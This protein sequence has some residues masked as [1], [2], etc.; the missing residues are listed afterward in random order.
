LKYFY[1]LFADRNLLPLD[2]VVFNTEA[3]PFPRIELG[4]LFWTG[5][6]RKGRDSR[7]FPLRPAVDEEQVTTANTPSPSKGSHDSVKVQ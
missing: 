3:H 7:G 2:Q 5:W 1:L 4:N 6:K